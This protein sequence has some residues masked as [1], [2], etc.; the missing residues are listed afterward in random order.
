[1]VPSNG[2]RRHGADGGRR[3]RA[4]VAN[5]VVMLFTVG[6]AAPVA[7][8]PVPAQD[9]STPWA[10]HT[11]ASGPR[12]ADGV[13]LRDVDRD[14]LA[15]VTTGWEEA[16]LVTVSLHPG[17][18]SEPWPTVTVGT[19]LH[20]VED[21]IFADVDGDGNLDVVSA[22]EC[23]RVVV[24]FGPNP[25][26][27]R[28]PAAWIPVVISASQGG[29][30]WIK[31]AVGDVDGDGRLD[32]V[33]GGKV[34]PATVGWF[35]APADPR[36]GSAWTYAPM[37][38]VGWT[39]SLEA[40]DVDQ[41]DDLDVVL[42]DRLPIRYPGGAIRYDLRGSRWLENTGTGAG[43]VNHPIGFGQGEHKFLRLADVDGDG[44]DDV[45]DGVSGETYN[46]TYL[47]RNL[48][49]WGP[50][51][52]TEIPQPDG[53]GWYQDGAT[54]DVDLDGDLDLVFSYSH[55]DGDLSGVVWLAEA[56]DASWPRREIS[57]PDGTKFDNLDL[58]DV[59]GDQDLDVVTS[60]QVEQLGVVWYENPTR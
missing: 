19:N 2:D 29:Q 21:A 40:R 46:R 5:L 30:R 16:G 53:V 52:A 3:W 39:M 14:G 25:A 7:A 56:G 18:R 10:R 43:W 4:V 6:A 17:E 37:S 8:Q 41:D 15:D 11:I 49:L 50:W 33:G 1:M 60:E 51:K 38:E 31:V 9:A 12:G 57:G 26:Q 58:F 24:H 59:D 22:C 36:D 27:V 20:G 48:G 32:I 13:D 55:A 23:R 35:R 54:G 45:L 44:A 47:R 34:N 28:D 42:S